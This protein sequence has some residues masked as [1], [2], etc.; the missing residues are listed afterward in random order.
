MQSLAR[1]ALRR[2]LAAVLAL[3]SLSL[4]GT[5][6]CDEY[7]L[8]S[9]LF[10]FR[11]PLLMQVSLPE[12]VALDL[13][14]SGVVDEESLAISLDGAPLDP[15]LLEVT[16]GE[17]LLPWLESKRVEA[18]LPALED[19]E[20]WLAATASADLFFVRFEV[21]ALTRFDTTDL[22]RPDECEILNA[23][24]CALPFPSQ[25]FIVDAEGET[26]TGKRLAFPEI[27]IEGV[28]GP[29]LDP[30]P[31]ARLD[32]FAPTAQILTFLEGVDLEASGASRLVPGVPQSPPYVGVRTHDARSLDHDSPT[33]LIDADTG[34]RILHW[35]ELDATPEAVAD[36]SRRVLFIRPA[37][38]LDPD[39]RYIVALRDMRNAAGER[40]EPEPVFRAFRNRFPST[41][42]ALEARRGE[43]EEIF[44]TL[45][46]FGVKRRTLQLAF[47]FSTRSESQ[48]HER[49]LAMRDESLTWLES[50]APDDVSGFVGVQVEDFGDCSDPG[51]LTWRKVKGDF[52]GPNYLTGNIENPFQV[53]VLNVDADDM[54]VRNGTHP[55]AWSV[56][57]PC[58]VFLE[59][60]TGHPLLLGHGFLGQGEGLV[61][62]F[63]AGGFF[64]GDSPV[65]YIAGATD[66]RGLSR[67]LTGPDALNILFNVIG[68]PASGHRFNTFETLPHRLKQGM[69]NTLLLSRMMK[70][71]FFN[72]LEA[73]QRVPGDPATG[74]FTPDEE[75]FYFGVSLGGIYGTMYAGLNQDTIR[76]NVVVPA[77]NF[78]ILEQRSTQFP[79]FLDL[80]KGLGL[81]DP[82]DLALLLGIQHE[83]WVSADPTAYIR[84]VTGTVDAPLPDTPPKKMLVTVAFLDK[85][86]SNQATEIFARSMGVPNVEGS[87]QR[88]LVDIPDV[89]ADWAAGDPG[90]DSGMQIY[91]S[92]FFDIFDPAFDAVVPALGNLVPSRACDPHGAPLATPAAIDQ[93]AA[94]L[95]PGG[96]IWSFCD[97]AC[98]AQQVQDAPS[99]ECDPLE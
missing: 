8:G 40:I 72:R 25:R 35:S 23:V 15:T 55:F 7:G 30:T 75:M 53:S 26:A 42:P 37:R 52:L 28:P 97:G 91:D 54:P 58:S 36:P 4:L 6:S 78:S 45:A 99:Y 12:G 11:A 70:S 77:M 38:A 87:V 68:T 31:L 46:H 27:V 96:R 19:G 62:S 56:A 57:V 92:G 9:P 90:L 32:G 71:G 81:T 39:H 83:L 13:H 80:I 59:Q 10:F 3:L 14:V 16:P 95:Q 63:A 74:V 33:V 84:N 21:H 94:F 89:P 1:P 48:L 88:A 69:V 2:R 18:V 65:E 34:E 67:G 47:A 64:A 73:L 49:M 98:D 17:G 86:V 60:E 43:M 50:L 20:H 93:I 44:A 85:Q 5:E 66:W 22:E 61:D 24:H 41:I 29:P 76:H 82:M 51:Q 79:V